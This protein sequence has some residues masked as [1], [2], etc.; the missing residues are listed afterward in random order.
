MSPDLNS[1]KNITELINHLKSLNSTLRRGTQR[2]AI[3]MLLKDLELMIQATPSEMMSSSQVKI[4]LL[5][6]VTIQEQ[7]FDIDER[8]HFIEDKLIALQDALDASSSR[9]RV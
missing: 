8:I 7:I 4:L 1:H 3:R 6:L 5:L 2:Q 9:Q